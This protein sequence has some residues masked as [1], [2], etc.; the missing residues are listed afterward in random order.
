MTTEEASD[1]QV[2]TISE[3][4]KLLGLER[5]TVGRLCAEGKIPVVRLSRRVLRIPRW[6]LLKELERMAETSI[7]E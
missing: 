7:G 1:K 4:A 2:L 6:L 3:A 5:H